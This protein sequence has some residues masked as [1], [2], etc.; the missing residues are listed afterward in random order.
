[1]YDPAIY[2]SKFANDGTVL[3][4]PARPLP[5]YN[6]LRAIKNFRLLIKNKEEQIKKLQAEINE[7]QKQLGQLDQEIQQAV[8]TIESTKGD[9]FASYQ[10]LVTQIQADITK[11]KKYLK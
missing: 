5:R 1:M 3:R 4:D 7:H 10:H 8:D 9:F 2:A 6:P 11:M